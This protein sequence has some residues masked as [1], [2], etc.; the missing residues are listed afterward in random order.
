VA[1]RKKAE[2]GKDESRGRVVSD[3]TRTTCFE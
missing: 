2:T 3:E 1:D